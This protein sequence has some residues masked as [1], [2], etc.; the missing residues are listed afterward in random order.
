[1][2][3]IINHHF[4]D[5]SQSINLQLIG[6]GAKLSSPYHIIGQGTFSPQVYV[7]RLPSNKNRNVIY[8][9]LWEFVC[10]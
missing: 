5:S 8:L 7:V 6:T 3:W 9:L 4:G 2:M 10:I 1:M